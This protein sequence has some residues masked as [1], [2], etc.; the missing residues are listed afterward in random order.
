M[1]LQ[2]AIGRVRVLELW[3]KRISALVHFDVLHVCP[4]LVAR[5]QCHETLVKVN[6]RACMRCLKGMDTGVRSDREHPG[7]KGRSDCT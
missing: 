6:R 3:G 1:S 5:L 7:K 2:T 4:S